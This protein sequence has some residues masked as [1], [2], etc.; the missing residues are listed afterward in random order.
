MSQ[1]ANYYYESMTE[2]ASA[3]GMPA[4]SAGATEV[5][6]FAGARS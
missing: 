2:A 1:A 4:W 3:S 5:R 6:S